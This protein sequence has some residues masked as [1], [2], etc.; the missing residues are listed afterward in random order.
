M[1]ENTEKELYTPPVCLYWASTLVV[2]S[3]LGVW[4]ASG[5]WVA[6]W[7]VACLWGCMQFQR[8]SAK[9]VLTTNMKAGDKVKTTTQSSRVLVLVR[10]YCACPSCA[11]TNVIGTYL[12]IHKH[13]ES[14]FAGTSTPTHLKFLVLI[15]L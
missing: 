1:S 8:I 14:D 7:C 2:A 3:K 4:E 11:I 15:F 5:S 12:T 10:G 6:A 9:R 13:R